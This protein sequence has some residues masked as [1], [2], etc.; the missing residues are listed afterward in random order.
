L[1][2]Q[3]QIDNDDEDEFPTNNCPS[4]VNSL[5]RCDCSNEHILRCDAGRMYDLIIKQS[6]FLENEKGLFTNCNIPEGILINF[7]IK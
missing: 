3:D 7:I 4:Y 1:E 6:S 2:S 5:E